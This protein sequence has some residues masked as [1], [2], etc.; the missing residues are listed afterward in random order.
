VP[1]DFLEPG[2]DYLFQVF[3]IEAGDNQTISE[4]VLDTADAGLGAADDIKVGDICQKKIEGLSW[5][6]CGAAAADG[7][8]Y[9]GNDG[10]HELDV[11]TTGP[12]GTQC[13]P[14]NQRDAD[15]QIQIGVPYPA[16]WAAE[17][18]ADL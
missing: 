6:L 5:H 1:P 17:A 8:I 14:G 9:Y 2:T 16:N 7:Q 13:P 11:F 12:A 4:G 3:A 15:H 18:T 10:A